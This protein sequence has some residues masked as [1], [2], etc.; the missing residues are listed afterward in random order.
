MPELP[1][2]ETVRKT[3]EELITGKTIDHV[4]VGWPKMVKKPDDAEAFK[5]ML[6]KETV[7]AVERKG[8]FLKVIL[9]EHV[10]VSHLRMEGKY[11]LHQPGAEPSKHTHV[12]VTFT[13]GTA[14]HY[15]DVRKFGTMHL[16]PKGEEENHP[17]L[18][19]LGPEPVGPN[20]IQSAELHRRLMRTSRAVKA[21]LL[22]QA[23]L[24]GLG[25]I[26]VDEALFQAGI[27]PATPAHQL[28]AQEVMTLHQAVQKTLLDAIAQGGTSIRSY[29]NGRG[30]MGY[31]QQQLYVYGR[32][33]EQCRVCRTEIIRTVI[34]GRGT[35]ICSK[36]QPLQNK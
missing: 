18:S 21:A 22:D 5:T 31:F 23:V 36:C 8:K 27:H 28:T 32:A 3:L 4:W 30:E 1:E 19:K 11:A 14:L 34:A 9:H 15:A 13:D 16:F 33:K 7:E 35:H 6:L 25:N 24:T 10:L 20:A 17:P 12:I 26:Y 2:V 29:V